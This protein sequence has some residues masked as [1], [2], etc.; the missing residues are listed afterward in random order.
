[1]SAGRKASGYW[2]RLKGAEDGVIA[3]GAHSQ[4]DKNADKAAGIAPGEEIIGD[5]VKAKAR[6][7]QDDAEENAGP[8]PLKKPRAAK[9]TAD[10]EVSS[11][12]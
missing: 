2:H 11:L 8:Q 10:D 7:L 1:M 5:A 3:D 6:T 12:F 9:E 4:C